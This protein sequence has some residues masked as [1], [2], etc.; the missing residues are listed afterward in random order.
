MADIQSNININVDTTNA[1]AAI[2]NLQSQ[3]SA[4]HQQMQKSGSAANAAASAN[5]QRNLINSIN[6][7]K[8][9]S[10][11]VANVSTETE[12]FTNALE[13]NK[14]SMG[15]YFRY[16][17]A[18]SRTFGKM[19]RGEFDTI[20]KV[21][22]SRVRTLQTQYV[23]M[24]R[25]ASGAMK[26][27]KVRPL[28]L[29]MQNLSTQTM[30]AAQKQ[31]I[32][33][34]LLRQGS[35]NLLNFG[36]NTQWAGR[37]LM[38]G[39]TVPLG[40][41]GAAAISE[42]QKI[43]EQAIRLKRVYGDMFTTDAEVNKAVAD[44]K[45]LAEEFTK[46][47]IA[48]ESTI[49][50][51]ASVAQIGNTG[52]D[53]INQVTE[54][55]KL[56]VLGG[57]EQ[58]K[59]LDTTISLTNAFGIATEDL[60]EKI[61]FLNAA[62]N[63][64]IL[65]IDD[66][67]EA[68]PKA[69]SVVAQLGGSVEDLAFFLTAMREGGVNA[70]QAA[71]ALKSS[72]A[73]LVNPTK[74]AQEDLG[75]LG[76][77]ILS[78]VESNVGD[79]RGTIFDLGDAL[80]SLQPLERSRALEE[81]F[82]KFQFARMSTL[83]KNI[84][85]E[86]SQ[87]QEILKLTRSSAAELQILADRELSRVEESP[88]TKLQKQLERL[89]AALAP[90]GEE[91]VKLVTPI[92]EFITNLLK[93]FNEMDEG[94]KSFVTGLVT[95]LGLIAPAAIM[96]FGLVANGIA[97]LMKSFNA[98]RSFLQILSGS[99]R[100]ITTTTQYMT[101]EQLEG[102]SVATNLG[103]AHQYLAQQF[104]VEAGALRELTSV[105]QAANAEL[106][107]Y[108][109]N[110]VVTPA[111]PMRV[112]PPITRASTSRR[113]G[114]PGG[115]VGYNK[116]T[117]NVPGPRGAGDIVPAVLSPGEAVIP[118]RQSQKY[119]GFLE[120]IMNDQV[121]GMMFGGIMG[122][123][124]SR[125]KKPGFSEMSKMRQ[126]PRVVQKWM[127]GRKN[128]IGVRMPSD[129]LFG[130]LSRGDS[131]YSNLFDT[132]KSAVGDTP[133]KRALVEQQ[134]FGIN[135]SAP[136]SQRP[137]YGYMFNQE[138]R[139]GL[140]NSKNR[141]SN[142]LTRFGF[143]RRRAARQS[144]DYGTGNLLN[145][146]TLRYGNLTLVPN[147][148]AI[149]NRTTLTYGDSY[150]ARNEQFAT[151]LP[152]TQAG[153]ATQ[154]Q[155]KGAYTSKDKFFV[156]AQIMGGFD[157]KD[158]KRIITTQP[159][160]KPVIEDRL[161][162]AGY[163]IP[164]GLPRYSFMDQLK[165]IFYP[166]RA[167][168]SQLPTMNRQGIYKDRSYQPGYGRKSGTGSDII[169]EKGL[170]GGLFQRLFGAIKGYENG[171]FSVPGPKGAGDIVPAM[172]APGEAVVPA[173]Q[174]QK[175]AGLIKGIISDNI[176]GFQGGRTTSSGKVVTLPSGETVTSNTE[177]GAK[178]LQNEIEKL[179]QGFISL[180]RSLDQAEQEVLQLAAAAERGGALRA[181]DLAKEASIN[182][183]GAS[184]AA[185]NTVTTRTALGKS[186]AIK[187]NEGAASLHVTDPTPLSEQDK[188]ELLSQLEQQGFGDS[189]AARKLKSGNKVS[190]ATDATVIA[191]AIMNKSGKVSGTQ[192]SEI[193]ANTPGMATADLAA[194]TDLDPN[195]PV[196]VQAEQNMQ[197]Y[198]GAMGDEILTDKQIAEA[199]QKAILDAANSVG[200][201]SGKKVKDQMSTNKVLVGGRG[202][203]AQDKK[204]RVSFPAG[205][206][207]QTSSG[208]SA[209]GPLP[210]Q[211]T[212][213]DRGTVKKFH[214]EAEQETQRIAKEL[215]QQTKKKGPRR[216][217]SGAKTIVAK[218][219]KSDA[220][221][222][223]KEFDA[224]S[225]DPYILARDNRNSPHPQ[226]SKDGAADARSYNKSFNAQS[227]GPIPPGQRR[228]ASTP[229]GPPQR[230]S[231]VLPTSPG[232]VPQ[233]GG[234]TS[235]IAEPLETPDGKREA[236]KSA[237]G[238]VQRFGKGVKDAGTSVG[239]KAMSAF[240]KSNIGQSFVS[241]LGA[242]AGNTVV[243]SDGNVIYD[244]DKDV[245]YDSQGNAIASG[246]AAGQAGRQGAISEDV[247]VGPDGNPVVDKR[248]NPVSQKQ[249]DRQARKMAS[250]QK[251]GMV[252]GRLGG[253]MGSASMML[254]MTS[255]MPGVGDNPVMKAVQGFMPALFGLS[256]VLPMLAALPGP[257]SLVIA[258]L[259]ALG[260]GL[261]Q[262]NAE[263]EKSREEGRELGNALSMSTD[264]LI[265]MSKVAGTV[266]ATEVRRKEQE[267]QLTGT[268]EGQRQFGMNFMD[269]EAGS[270]LMEE[271]NTITSSGLGMDAAAESMGR[272]LSMA[273]M[274]GVLSPEQANS[275]VA[276]IGAEMNDYQFSADIQ[277][278]MISLIGPNGKDITKEPLEVALAIQAS[279]AEQI[280]AFSDMIN[281]RLSKDFD[282]TQYVMSDSESKAKFD[283]LEKDVQSQVE[284]RLS[285]EEDFGGSNPFLKAIAGF[286]GGLAD[287]LPLAVDDAAKEFISDASPMADS[288][289][290]QSA[291][292]QLGI[293][294]ISANQQILDSMESQYD[295]QIQSLEAQLKSETNAEKRKQ[296]EQDI[297]QIEKQKSGS[298]QTLN[299]ENAAVLDQ[300]V[301]MR[302]MYSD[303]DAF[304]K[305][306]ESSVLSR[307]ADDDPM[308]VFA[309]ETLN[310]LEKLEDSD[311]K[312]NIQLGFASGEMSI[313]NI[314]SLLNAFDKDPLI[315]VAFD[316]VVDKQG[317]GDASQL[318][319]L[320]G[321]AGV[322]GDS[323]FTNLAIFTKIESP[324][325]FDK[326]IAALAEISQLEGEYGIEINVEGDSLETR[327]AAVVSAM[328][329]LDDQ[330]DVI[331]KQ[332]LIELDDPGLQG[333]LDN[334]EMLTGSDDEIA[335]TAIFEFIAMSSDLTDTD[336]INRYI[337]EG[338]GG[339]RPP[340]LNRQQLLD[341]ATAFYQQKGN[342]TELE[343]EEEEKDPDP[344]G[345]TGPVASALDSIVSKL[346][347]VRDET[348]KTT[349]G[350]TA[351]IQQLQSL[352]GGSKTLTIFD[353]IQQ[354]LRK[355]G[356]GENL[357]ELIVGMDP[358]EFEKRK[359]DLFTIK[360]GQIVAL[361]DQAV[362]IGNALNSIKI[363]D[364]QNQQQELL[365]DF[366]NQEL[367]FK[368]L[369]DAGV[370]LDQVYSMIGDEALAAAIAS[371]ELTD[372]ELKELAEQLK[373]VS[374][375]MQISKALKS[376]R[377]SLQDFEDDLKLRFDIETYINSE[378]FE[379]L[380]SSI[381]DGFIDGSVASA[382]ILK[383]EALR[384]LIEAGQQ[385]GEEF[386]ER[387]TQLLS[388]SSF[389]QSIFDQGY[390]NVQTAFNVQS[391]EI[392]K[393]IA[394]AL[395]SGTLADYSFVDQFGLD[396]L[397]SIIGMSE[398]EIKSLMSIVDPESIVFNAQQQI[399]TLNYKIDDYEAGL[400]K[401]DREE[402]EI[403]K[404]YD[405]RIDA[406]DKIESVNESLVQEQRA[407]EA[408]ARS[409]EQK[410]RL[411]QARQ[412]ELESITVDV[413]GQILSR[414]EIE[415][416][417]K[418]LQN[419][420]LDIEEDRLE[421]AQ[422]LLG[423]SQVLA[424]KQIE[425][426]SVLGK[427]REQ[428]EDIK[429]EIDLA[430]I[431]SDDF[432]AS[433][434]ASANSYTGL[435]DAYKNPPQF[436]PEE[437]TV[438]P[439]D[440]G[441]AS[442]SVYRAEGVTVLDRET[443]ASAAIAAVQSGEFDS[444]LDF[445]NSIRDQVL[446]NREKVRSG[447][448][449]ASEKDKLVKENIRLM[450]T[451]GLKFAM[452]GYVRQMLARG[453][454]VS[455]ASG[456]PSQASS[457]SIGY[458]L[459]AGGGIPNQSAGSGSIGYLRMGGM[460]PYKA[461]GGLFQSV[462]TDIV[463]AMLTPGE[464]VVRRSSVDKYGKEMLK[465]INNGTYNGES[466][467]NYSVN[468]NVKSDAN[469]NDIAK[470]VM[471][472]IKQIDSQRI[473]SNRF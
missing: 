79:L 421:P 344:E 424:D 39:F 306:I 146:E 405:E 49:G 200:G 224:K 223:S 265:E 124:M 381:E 274:Q 432:V 109:A 252:A 112:A 168:E 398:E 371:A 406:L 133:D 355:L 385:G 175:Y 164:V 289:K 31:Q 440:D 467:Y 416:R 342:K 121:P 231:P 229:A 446:A 470:T 156:E 316:L 193:V 227:G 163:N 42:F 241:R 72:L 118:A 182:A 391:T 84:S 87:A 191:P 103:Q 82:G 431:A 330:P 305:A 420:I 323:L 427:T 183:P 413:N 220:Q 25:D 120:A 101:Q 44:V 303:T 279:G 108:N 441:Q 248:G 17:G 304:D 332:T 336:L 147:K 59:A 45:Q 111:R 201:S 62:E 465:S 245:Q 362:S 250:R 472:Q 408:A 234:F 268:T 214:A 161:R 292:I 297:L 411:E 454:M 179:I 334:W 106:M 125:F 38:V 136:G 58:E 85:R 387:I 379:T 162:K 337:Q 276:A 320:L 167:S 463:P 60:T 213:L 339:Y 90:I 23:K 74:Q 437:E 142:F 299:K 104:T 322:E 40:I 247:V 294:Q 8:K 203:T 350:W 36:K 110:S 98:Y 102:A 376:A 47:G 128:Q 10:A 67:T 394:N 451:S 295:Q 41:M 347:D 226:S 458:Y 78:I 57:M 221:V 27:I 152:W 329:T 119:S 430:K 447:N 216:S 105:Y 1:M 444:P 75:K 202:T 286:R 145:K 253:A 222:Y 423:I 264:K 4:F 285:L 288:L 65:A 369:V 50:L 14:L 6:A 340:G 151:P 140:K 219:A 233:P 312:T 259:G 99:N 97:N 348:I 237:K 186:P 389:L 37:Q 159:R 291:G 315:G 429:H 143:G 410:D 52:A 353:G 317:M 461:A 86:G 206:K 212:Y 192:A 218:D 51:A 232:G 455:S 296:L 425:Y 56:A 256:A 138:R 325:E 377:T 302:D 2:R 24:G 370:D 386:A 434:Q 131:R 217:K 393:N 88:A 153:K 181:E 438:I 450:K 114:S 130:M 277:G 132:G 282:L 443:A 254:G 354:S 243:G 436:S 66:F 198:L 236:K 262:Y 166:N 126:D 149:K 400:E 318:L 308:K 449:S 280:T 55:T 71:N 11:S 273:V 89:Q 311:F 300:I 345:D 113:A 148:K 170:E 460:I 404:R 209:E 18:S 456:I 68:V 327:L 382:A 199:L 468:V 356:A 324:E 80:D 13:K 158:V 366:E 173:Q 96:T 473:R 154:Q 361:K 343:E 469:A 43:E 287:L 380:A 368:K 331:S 269:S 180:G 70:S 28:S 115:P 246:M 195:D 177:V 415:N 367:A 372:T 123:M 92:A 95:V 228:R 19:F 48:I 242:A 94:A 260:F 81:L 34:Q 29:D 365:V 275:V 333:I 301:E 403:N 176:P 134:L 359:N 116:G 459:A 93:K 215:D 165:R 211:K 358:E 235:P 258:A 53:M 284:F 442:Q 281:E 225:K 418:D 378:E 439:E 383:D 357:I 5:M 266:S 194:A 174:T 12:S 22:E 417:I 401:I 341:R 293:N 91:F 189:P 338:L 457:N 397:S 32:F 351:S 360:N 83:F 64:T 187:G 375:S 435:I 270:S 141:F 426:Q 139:V 261:Y 127:R 16:A 73:R 466:V 390:S 204:A 321:N 392:R 384:A 20:S 278:T 409:Q 184:M 3:I 169:E 117:L 129:E 309:E 172:L 155:V 240:E 428:W 402:D 157:L 196:F 249:A 135:P 453:G 326:N 244:A 395:E 290:L 271:I 178:K 230:V 21:A 35:T 433:M 314:Q 61:N 272:Q 69:G 137:V 352:F 399:D 210:G 122:R 54:A 335:K 190:A 310:T 374:E 448:L 364:F 251:R 471:S 185:N 76:I 77:D 239:K 349:K 414:E 15:Q 462:N 207:G 396:E 388:D 407:A 208:I 63:Q 283:E 373:E 150:N 33:N 267:E 419:D 363:G 346:R 205:F 100:D 257:V 319:T 171:V 46:Y 422:R 160:L 30:I 107:R 263:I 26:A 328:N 9:F 197:D 452:G 307:F 255:M 445:A 298:I 7:T 238:F 144:F 188:S 464:Y 412:K 313:S